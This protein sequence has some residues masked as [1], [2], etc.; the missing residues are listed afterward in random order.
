VAT[1][2]TAAD[3]AKKYP[4]ANGKSY[5]LG[6]ANYNYSHKPGYIR[7]PYSSSIYDCSGIPKGSFILDSHVNKVFIKP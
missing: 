6:D 5:P 2:I 4:P 1:Q 7:S 3:A